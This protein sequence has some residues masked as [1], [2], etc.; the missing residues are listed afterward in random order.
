MKK[1]FYTIILFV[2][3]LGNLQEGFAISKELINFDKYEKNLIKSKVY[4]NIQPTRMQ[5]PNKVEKDKVTGVPIYRVSVS[6]M[7]IRRWLVT[8][9]SSGTS[10]A[11]KRYSYCKPV[12][13]KGV[14]GG[15]KRWVLGARIH[16][17]RLPYNTWAKIHPPFEIIAF[18]K[19]GKFVNIENGVIDNTGQLFQIILEVNGRNYNNSITIRMKN[20]IDE[21]MDYFM[22]YLY[23]AGWKKLIW[24]NPNYI[25]NVDLREIFRLPLYPRSIPYK[26]FVCFIIM[27]QGTEIGGDFIV[28]I[29]NVRVSYDKAIVIEEMDID[30]EAAWQIITQQQRARAERDR[31]VNT[32]IIDIRRGEAKRQ[33]RASA[34]MQRRRNEETEDIRRAGGQA[35][36]GGNQPGTNQPGANQPGGNQPGGNQPG[37]NQ[38][39]PN[40]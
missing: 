36:A 1:L 3:I 37:G 15:K 6:D 22:G 13:T 35:P 27:R 17:H 34:V 9:N 31:R 20:D 23:F 11:A 26:K 2:L 10:V 40:N 38:N 18:N 7:L 24:K 5:D 33:H 39:P 14:Y 19:E 21:E 29:A 4:P 25:E 30:D 32:A 12:Q 28:Y 8:I 16:F